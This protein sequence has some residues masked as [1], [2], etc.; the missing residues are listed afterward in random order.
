MAEEA[1]GEAPLGRVDTFRAAENAFALDLKAE[2][3]EQD[4]EP[5]PVEEEVSEEVEEDQAEEADFET[6][7]PEAL[8]AEQTYT[9]KANGQEFEVSLQELKDSFSRQQDYTQKTTALS[10]EK[11]QLAERLQQV[12]ALEG[13]LN[14]LRE[15]AEQLSAVSSDPGEEYW[16]QLKVENPMQYMIERDEFREKQAEIL[17]LKQETDGMQKQL[18]QQRQLE[19]EQS[20]RA[21]NEKLLEL[22]PAWA[23]KQKFSLA[24]NQMRET[25]KLVGF[26]EDDLSQVTDHRTVMILHKAALWDALQKKTIK[27]AP[28]RTTQASSKGTVSKSA[29]K[30]AKEKL[31]KTGRP[32]DAQNAF[33]LLLQ[34]GK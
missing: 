30:K 26:S 14:T 6:E 8:V 9:V 5:E 22:N 2:E 33:E 25:A 12:E 4:S 21:E 29:L 19:A 24:K 13:Q 3:P 16:N 32:A 11:K 15:N 27:P 17:R 1:S 23:D 7:E 18:H 34:K 28:A 10:E 20:L 31:A